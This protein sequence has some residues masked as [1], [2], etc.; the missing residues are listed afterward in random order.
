[1]AAMRG[2]GRRRAA[3]RV[4]VAAPA[5]AALVLA[6]AAAH[7][8]CGTLDLQ[9]PLTTQCFPDDGTHHNV[10]CVDIDIPTDKSDLTA[11]ER[12]IMMASKPQSFS[13]C[14]CSVGI[15]S[16]LGGRVEW[17]VT[18]RSASA[19]GT[20]PRCLS[21]PAVLTQVCVCA[22]AGQR[23]GT[24][25]PRCACPRHTCERRAAMTSLCV[26]APDEQAR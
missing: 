5:L 15:C 14:T 6:Q 18:A 23:A 21:V 8:S 24:N 11:L 4:I 26:C 17:K 1:M 16:K 22:H 9:S 25:T 10:C 20:R 12:L 2:G 13:W 7:K 3:A 19:R